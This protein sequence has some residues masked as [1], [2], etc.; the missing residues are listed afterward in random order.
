M[1]GNVAWMEKKKNLYKILAG[2][3]E[4]K[5]PIGRPKLRWDNNIKMDLK[6]I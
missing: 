4:E 2:K 3:P 5:K 6:E 1:G